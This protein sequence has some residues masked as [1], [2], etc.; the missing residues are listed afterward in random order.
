MHSEQNENLPEYSFALKRIQ[1]VEKNLT[2]ITS[3]VDPVDLGFDITLNVKLD[4]PKK[5]SAHFMSVTISNKQISK[6]IA[7]LSIVCFFDIDNIEGHTINTGGQLSLPQPLL[8]L[9]NTVVIGTL[10]GVLYS[11]LRGTLLDNA[12]LPVLDPR[13]FQRSP[14]Q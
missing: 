4:I 3:K 1:T 10:R 11:E 8:N 2:L 5:I 12:L 13:K 7:S 14:N 6:T 9:L